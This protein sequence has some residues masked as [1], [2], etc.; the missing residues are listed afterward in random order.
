MTDR[1]KPTKWKV[2][3]VEHHYGNE[4]KWDDYLDRQIKILAKKMNRGE[5]I[6]EKDEEEKSNEK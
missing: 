6:L 1:A 3:Y 2:A 4:F 5:V